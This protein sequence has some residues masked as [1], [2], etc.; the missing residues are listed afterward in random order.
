M[1]SLPSIAW[2]LP[3][4]W[5][6]NLPLNKESKCTAKAVMLGMGLVDT[7]VKETLSLSQIQNINIIVQLPKVEMSERVSRPRLG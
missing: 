2:K 5:T 1:P 4:T 6:K 7:E 3:E